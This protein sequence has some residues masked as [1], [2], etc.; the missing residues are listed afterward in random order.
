[1]N[2][3]VNNKVRLIVCT[4]KDDYCRRDAVHQPLHVG[5]ALSDIYRGCEGD[6][7]GV[8]ISDKNPIYCELSGLYWAWKNVSNV[9]Y[10]GLVHYRRYFKL[11]GAHFWARDVYVVT[12]TEFN[13][14]VYSEASISGI[15]GLYDVILPKPKIFTSSVRSLWNR[16]HDPS[17]LLFLEALISQISPEYLPSFQRVF[18]GNTAS[19]YNMFIMRWREMEKYC[20]WLFSILFEVEK[21]LDLG[22]GRHARIMGFLSEFLID[23]YVGH[24]RMNIFYAPVYLLSDTASDRGY[25]RYHLSRLKS[26]MRFRIGV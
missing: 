7:S 24:H 10:F 6:D 3:D 25:I 8:N 19:Q 1:M 4:H 23:V 12:P 5:K 9:E 17:D 2:N 22:D 14:V 18:S 15:L 11:I 20:T 16:M 21:H 13:K 26:E